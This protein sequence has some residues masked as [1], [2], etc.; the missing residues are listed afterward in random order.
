MN[1]EIDFSKEITLDQTSMVGEREALPNMSDFVEQE[2]SPL[3]DI[4]SASLTVEQEKP[5]DTDYSTD[6]P[7]LLISRKS[8]LKVLNQVVAILNNNARRAVDRGITL[9]VIDENTVEAITPGELYYYKAI[10]PTEEP[11]TL[12]IGTTVFMELITIQKLVKFLLPKVRITQTFEE[13]FGQNIEKFH[14]LLSTDELTLLNSKLIQADIDRLE[15]KNEYESPEPV[16][17]VRVIDFANS[18]NTLFK[19]LPFQADLKKRV[20]QLKDGMCSFK[21]AQVYAASKFDMLDLQLRKAELD[22]IVRTSKYADS[23]SE[24]IIKKIKS[25]IPRYSFECDGTTLITNFA[26]PSVDPILEETMNAIPELVPIDY[27]ELKY[28]L[29]YSNSIT[30]ALGTI[31]LQVKSGK[32]EGSINLKSGSSPFTLPLQG[33]LNLP[34]NTKINI[35]SKTFLN[36]LN[37]LNPTLVTKFGISNGLVYLVNDEVTVIIITI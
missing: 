20:V 16:K 28:Q 1:E 6:L 8:L 34:E 7:H 17:T 35:N 36:C 33:D 13:E 12:P 2:K 37:S 9:K 22:Y 31:T 25:T 26:T 21:A 10:I 15:D 4:I 23:T 3:D 11:C 30:Y 29:D 27:S 32:V 24:F 19:V 5:D 18:I 14:I